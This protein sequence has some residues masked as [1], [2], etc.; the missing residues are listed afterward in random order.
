MVKRV[1]LSVVVSFSPSHLLTFAAGMGAASG[2]RRR[3]GFCRKAEAE[4]RSPRTD[5]AK[6]AGGNNDKADSP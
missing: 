3:F 5:Y 4:G 2:G 1:A 6:P